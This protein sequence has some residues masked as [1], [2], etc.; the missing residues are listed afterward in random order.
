MALLVRRQAL[1]S[2]CLPVFSVLASI[3]PRLA[4]QRSTI[5]DLAQESCAEHTGTVGYIGARSLFLFLSLALLTARLQSDGV[6]WGEINQAVQSEA[7]ADISAIKDDVRMTRIQA[8]WA[9]I[10]LRVL[11]DDTRREVRILTAEV[12]ANAHTATR[13]ISTL[14]KPA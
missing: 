11:W 3:Y 14:I 9:S 2:G 12:V 10:E 4:S 8:E 7:R 6:R 13:R 1:S 5:V